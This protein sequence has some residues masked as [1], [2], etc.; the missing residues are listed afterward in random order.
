MSVRLS[1][2]EI[3]PLDLSNKDEIQFLYETRRHPE[4]ARN[5]FGKPPADMESHLTWLTSN[6]PSEKRL[7]Y[8]AHYESK[9]VGYCQATPG[10]A[11]IELG[12]V[13]HPAYQGNGHGSAMIR[14][15]VAEMRSRFPE[16]EIILLVQ[17]ENERACRLYE[18][19]G[20]WI[21][22]CTDD[23]ITYVWRGA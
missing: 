9:C 4:I 23:V 18:R 14:W 1:K 10:K 11:H 5:L 8:L 12:F 16:Q 17:I 15:M 20:F 6:L 21:A 2:V 7:L 19:S 13:V 22:S 3:V